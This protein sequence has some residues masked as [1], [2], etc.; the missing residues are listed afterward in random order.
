MDF[1]LNFFGI[2]LHLP[3]IYLIFLLPFSTEILE[4]VVCRCGFNS[5][6]FY[7]LFNTLDT[8][9]PQQLPTLRCRG[10]AQESKQ[11]EKQR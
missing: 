8:V 7:S 9:I 6:R 4:R 10:R 2:F 11:N 1:S 3:E 5:L